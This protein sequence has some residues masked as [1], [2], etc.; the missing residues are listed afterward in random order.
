MR[1]YNGL[2]AASALVAVF[3][4]ISAPV[5]AQTQVSTLNFDANPGTVGYAAPVTPSA[6]QRVGVF[7]PLN[8][9]GSFAQFNPAQG[10]LLSATFTISFTYSATDTFAKFGTGSTGGNLASSGTLSQTFT[11]SITVPGSPAVPTVTVSNTG[12]T[13]FSIP[14]GVGQTVTSPAFSS[15]SSGTAGYTDAA[16][17]TSLTGSGTQT[18]SGSTT[19]TAAFTTVSNNGYLDASNITITNLTG[20]VTYNYLDPTPAPPGVI[21]GLIGIAMGGAQFGVMKFRRRRAKKTEATE[22]AA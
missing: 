1:K 10:Q 13:G 2:V 22:V 6:A 16:F 5:M 11:T 19:S 21:S 3:G 17:L 8:L 4:G 9:T 14:Q 15:S 12:S 20:T 7:T 18:F